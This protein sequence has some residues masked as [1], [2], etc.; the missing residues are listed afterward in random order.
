MI[1]SHH[2]EMENQDA[3]WMKHRFSK[4]DQALMHCNIPMMIKD[5]II[6]ISALMCT[7]I[8]VYMLGGDEKNHT[9]YYWEGWIKEL[10]EEFKLRKKISQG[11]TVVALQDD[12][13]I[14]EAVQDLTYR[15][16]SKIS[17]KNAHILMEKLDFICRD[18]KAHLIL[19]QI[20][21]FLSHKLKLK[22]KYSLIDEYYPLWY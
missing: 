11:T 2:A 16:L 10:L 15:E 8:E 14:R 20:C 3:D 12:I 1:F 19:D 4:F 22:L 7:L 6:L 21:K 13:K 18:D 5:K 17:E 9:L